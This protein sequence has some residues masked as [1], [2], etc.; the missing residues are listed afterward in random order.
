MSPLTVIAIGLLLPLWKAG[1]AS[2]SDS[3]RRW[4]TAIFVVAIVTAFR[5]HRWPVPVGGFDHSVRELLWRRGVLQAA[6]DLAVES[7]HGHADFAR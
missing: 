2:L 6:D 4:F 1:I 7:R 3:E 5:D